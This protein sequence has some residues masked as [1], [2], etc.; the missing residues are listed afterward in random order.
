MRKNGLERPYSSMQILTW[1]LLPILFIQFGFF[2]T[3]ILPMVASIPCTVVFI[4][5]GFLSI[6]YGYLCCVTDPIDVKLREHLGRHPPEAALQFP[7]TATMMCCFIC[8]KCQKSSDRQEKKAIDEFSDN[9]MGVNA[10]AP[11]TGEAVDGSTKGSTG[12]AVEGEEDTKYCWVCETRVE[13]QSM[14]CKYC[15]KCVS[16]FDH[17]CQWLNTCVGR[18]N[19]PYF[20]RTVV[21]TF[22]FVLVHVL[23]LIAIIVL[24]FLQRYSSEGG[25]IYDRSNEW[26]DLNAGIV[27]VGVNIGFLVINGFSL[28]LVFQLLTFHIGLRREGITTYEFILRDNIRRREKA[29]INSNIKERRIICVQDAKGKNRTFRVFHLVWGGWVGSLFPSCDPIRA[30]HLTSVTD[31]EEESRSTATPY[32]RGGS[33]SVGSSMIDASASEVSSY[34]D[35]I[36]VGLDSVEL[37]MP[38]QQS[39]LERTALGPWNGD[40]FEGEA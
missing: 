39:L 14:H 34:H 16:G 26:F 10:S 6:Y 24:Y 13:E 11:S 38:T 3:P 12:E 19:Y 27:I 29:R 1:I 32:R 8:R 21:V 25:T 23:C 37:S 30:E 18:H 17:H 20:Y 22:C 35:E 7:M 2:V 28:S 9:E 40:T 31:E 15:D 33:V 4:V 5:F 36:S